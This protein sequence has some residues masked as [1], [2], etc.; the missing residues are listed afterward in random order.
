G[1]KGVISDAYS[2]E[3]A[4]RRE[5]R[6]QR[7]RKGDSPPSTGHQR[8]RSIGSPTISDEDELMNVWRKNRLAE[9]KASAAT[10]RRQSPSKRS[11][12][13]VEPVDAAGYLD[14]IEKV[15]KDTIVVVA[16]YSDDS[17]ECSFVLDCLVTIAKRYPTT[18][19][20]K[21]HHSEAEMDS[22]VVPALLAYKGGDLFHSVMRI[23]DEIPTGRSLSTESLE[24]VLRKY[25]YY[26]RTPN[27]ETA[28]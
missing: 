23:V 8:G 19:F 10:Q 4:K 14:A 17:P 26:Q 24:L 9:L 1:V 18:R 16:I 25:V 27:W 6:E 12:G 13:R 11:Y 7:Q 28:D 20:V 2:F 21:L 15:S 3:N 22:E 5:L